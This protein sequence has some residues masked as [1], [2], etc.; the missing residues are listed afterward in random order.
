MVCRRRRPQSFGDG[1]ERCSEAIESYGF[2]AEGPKRAE[3]FPSEGHVDLEVT[4]QFWCP[5]GY[6]AGTSSG[7]LYTSFDKQELSKIDAIERKVRF[8][9]GEVLNLWQPADC[10][11]SAEPTV[12]ADGGACDNMGLLPLLRRGVERIIQVLSITVSVLDPAF[13]DNVWWPSLFGRA[14]L[15]L[16]PGDP[17]PLNV[18]AQ[19]F[20]SEKF[21]ELMSQLKRRMRHGQPPVVEQELEVLP[22]EYCGVA[23][24][25]T[26]RILWCVLDMPSGFLNALPKE[27]RSKITSPLPKWKKLKR[28]DAAALGLFGE[29]ID[30][31]FPHVTTY[32]GN[33][34]PPLCRL[35]A[36]LM[37]YNIL[38]GVGKW[39]L[40]RFVLGE[41]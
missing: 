20:P 19:V 1:E 21:D 13:M 30:Q 29:D 14:T 4:P 16:V 9:G 28:L 3:P 24:G 31:T 23:K 12:V 10:G 32:F 33:Y 40:R 41:E 22:N 15:G 2:T 36:E 34:S 6:Q 26:V 25:Y 8:L 7:A 17:G 27:T 18:R 39:S 38:N 5:L 37:A 11:H 35:L